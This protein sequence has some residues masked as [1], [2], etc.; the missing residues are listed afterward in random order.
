MAE[1]LITFTIE[2]AAERNGNVTAE[3]FIAKLRQFVT[4]IYA[5]ERAFTKRDQRNLD[6]EI[7]ELSR[8]NPAQVKLKARTRVPGYS[9][10]PALT[11]TFDQISRVQRGEPVDE[12]VPQKALDNVIELAKHRTKGAHDFN[13]LKVLFPKRWTDARLRIGKNLTPFTFLTLL[14]IATSSC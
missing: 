13:L 10:Q 5:F 9:A 1:E 2:G 14:L 12:S 7:V 8:K 4:T 11:W 6:L 3:T